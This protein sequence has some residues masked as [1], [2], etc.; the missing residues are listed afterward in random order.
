VLSLLQGI[1]NVCSRRFDRLRLESVNKKYTN[2]YD[3]MN[4][5]S[6]LNTGRTLHIT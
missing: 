5:L 1:L 4:E 6:A 3:T 2:R